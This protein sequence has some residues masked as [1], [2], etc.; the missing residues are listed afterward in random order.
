ME[1]LQALA[2]E[3]LRSPDV[4][5]LLWV[6]G[7]VLAAK[8]I[9]IV[10]SRAIRRLVRHTRT[11]LDDRILGGASQTHFP[12]RGAPGAGLCRRGPLAP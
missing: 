4:Q 1:T 2:L 5:A 6:V 8:L 12:E 10:V 7:S 3:V 11:T 9:D